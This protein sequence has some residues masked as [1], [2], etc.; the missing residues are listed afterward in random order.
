M[1]KIFLIFIVLCST[2]IS[3]TSQLHS[4]LELKIQN[5]KIN[6]QN[7]AIHNLLIKENSTT[8]KKNPGLAILY[9]LLLPGMGE[10]YAGNYQSGKYFTM[11]DGVIWGVLAGFNIYGDWQEEN[12]R[13][14]AKSNANVDLTGKTSEFFANIGSHLSVDDFNR[15]Q[16]LNRDFEKVYNTTSHYWKW[17]SNDQRREYRNMWS[18]SEQ[19]YNNV[20]FAVGALLLNRLISAINAVRLVTAFNK[21][22][23]EENNLQVSF[24]INQTATLPNYLSINFHTKF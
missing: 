21:N 4:I 13:A 3:Q 5:S 22:I 2:V 18:S 6:F 7:P 9:S 24:G 23:S 16:E 20:R 15:I 12:Y 8:N 14:F 11:A 1:K 17:L 10:L 19:A